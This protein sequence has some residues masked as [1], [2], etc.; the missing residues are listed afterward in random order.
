VFT[1]LIEEVG[2]IAQV[3]RTRGLRLTV[4]AQIVMDDLKPGDS[5][6]VNGACLTAEAIDGD[7]FTASLLPETAQ[8][9]T[10]GSLQVGARVNLERPLRVGDRL[11]GH[12]VSGHVD[13]VGEV[14]AAVRRGE[15]QWV[16]VVAPE[17][18]ARYLVDRGSVA[19]DGVSL[20]VREPRGRRF[21]VSLVGATL[22]ATTLG[23]LHAGD[24]VNLEADL[25]AKHIERLL[26]QGEPGADERKLVEWLA[27]A[28]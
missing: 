4:H 27:E 8:G 20:T 26:Q 11:G 16:E 5:I 10:L 1:G 17:G 28:E 25:L 22:A 13:G 3:H 6:A 9:T 18:M 15:T 14:A 24:L 23:E 19:L 12:L 2:T 7:R 21:A